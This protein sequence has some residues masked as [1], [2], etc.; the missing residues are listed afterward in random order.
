MPTAEQCLPGTT[1]TSRRQAL[2]A[3]ATIA[4]I[5]L[6]LLLRFGVQTSAT[7]YDLSLEESW[8]RW[9]GAC[10]RWHTASCT[11]PLQMSRSTR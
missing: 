5:G 8:K 2:I 7:V 1:F 10:P 3:L 9:P 4:A 6:H 11:V